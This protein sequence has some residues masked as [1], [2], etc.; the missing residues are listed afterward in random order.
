MNTTTAKRLPVTA[1]EYLEGERKSE[2]RHEFVDGRIYAMS[3]ASLQHNEICGE[4]YTLL[5]S[6]L[7]GGPCR[8]FIEAVKVELADDLVA[9]YYYPDV[10]VT[11][12]PA[13]DDSHVVRHPKLIIEVLSPSTSRNDRGD[14]LANY[15]RIPSVEE[16]VH[17]EQ[18][19]PEIFLVR[20]ADRWKK[21]LYTQLDSPV[22]LE[23]IDLTLPVSAFYRAAPFPDDVARPWY[24]RYRED[25]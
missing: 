6:H 7:R 9:A 22:H 21:H 1:S 17:V 23:S 24:L 2:V 8:T 3:G 15:K 5:K 12:E 14:K 4:I 16:I 13:D 25:G 11:C 18:D 19:W 10:F 20:R